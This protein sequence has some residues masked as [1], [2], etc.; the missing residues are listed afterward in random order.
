MTA[1]QAHTLETA[2]E[3]AHAE[4][5]HIIGKGT[6]SK[7]FQRFWL[8]SSQDYCQS[9]RVYV[10]RLMDAKHPYLH[11][12]CQAGQRGQICKHRAVVHQTLLAEME[13]RQVKL[14]L[15]KSERDAA[16][17]A[18]RSARYANALPADDTREFSIYR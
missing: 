12:N 13:A 2:L 3:R 16:V 6:M 5:I 11:C 1:Q 17:Q 18:E 15:T 14:P 4:G 10:V 7:T 9:N 8:V